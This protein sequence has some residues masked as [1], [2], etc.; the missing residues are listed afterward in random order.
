MIFRVA[1]RQDL[2]AVLALLADGGAGAGGTGGAGDRVGAPVPVEAGG[3]HERAFA[4]IE[5]DPRNELLVLQDGDALVGCLQLTYIPGLGQGGRERALVEAVRIR[6]DR[7]GGGLGAE[8]MAL[9]VERARGRGC[10]LVQLTSDKR[11]TA[12][13]RFYERLGFARSHEGFKLRL[14]P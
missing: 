3:A 4:A 6:A 12:A 14:E 11:R 9:A 8:L 13:H 10:G 5:A 2:P 1:T 7:R